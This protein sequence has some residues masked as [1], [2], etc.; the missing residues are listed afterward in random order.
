MVN[1]F[2]GF[3]K[4]AMSPLLVTIFLTALAVSLVAMILSWGSNASHRD[5]STC[6]DVG[7]SVQV[8]DGKELI[9]FDESSGRLRVVVSNSGDVSIE[10]IIHRQIGSDFEFSDDVVP[11]SD[12]AVGQILSENLLLRPGKARVEL[13]PFISVLGENVLC[14]SKAVVRENVVVCD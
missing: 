2:F 14:S 9:C 6:D 10:G 5:S 4:K 3:N 13:I 12:L 1:M 11:N 8:A 7:I